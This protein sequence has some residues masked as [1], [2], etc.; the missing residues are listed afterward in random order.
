MKVTDMTG[1]GASDA[2][3]NILITASPGTGKTTCIRKVAALLRPHPLAGF[4]TAEIRRDGK[5]VG[6]EM[7]TFDGKRRVLASVDLKGSR[8]VGNYVVD[9]RGFE[10]TAVDV[11]GRDHPR[12]T[13]FIID[14]IGKM[15]CMSARFRE[16]VE[17]ILDGKH[18]VL[19]AVARK[20]SGFI[21]RTLARPDV[22]VVE[23]TRRNREKIPEQLVRMLGL[24]DG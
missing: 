13:V 21:D 22:T 7:I 6:F 11:L 16:L 14:E 4:F 2:P 5:R 15:E 23:V 19:A 20:G 18:R 8:R 17:Q 3:K 12:E 24:G 1:G 10:R 9:V